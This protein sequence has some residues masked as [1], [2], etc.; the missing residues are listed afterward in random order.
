MS[1][2]MFDFCLGNSPYQVESKG[3]NDT[4]AMPVYHY[5]MDASSKIADTTVLIH[6]ARFL[7]GIG[8][9]PKKF[10]EE[11]LNDD[12]FKVLYY[13]PDASKVFPNTDIK[14]GIVITTENRN[15][16]YKKI[17]VFIPYKS[18][19]TVFSKVWEEN[20]ESFQ[21]L[22]SH[23]LI[24]HYSNAFFD[25]FPTID[26]TKGP[27]HS[28]QSDAFDKNDFV[29]LKAKNENEAFYEFLGKTKKESGRVWRYI[30]KEYIQNN[31][32]LNNWK[33]LIS[34]SVGSGKF[35]ETL[36]NPIVAKP[37]TGGTDTFICIGP[38]NCKD[39]AESALKYIST[40]FAR[41][42]LGILRRT[43]GNTY[44]VWKY[45][46]LQDFTDHSDIDWSKSIPEIDQQLYRKYGL[47][48]EEIDFIETH[49][50]EMK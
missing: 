41:A 47:S 7:F 29:F 19:E 22:I 3:D 25:D 43:Q 33:I 42:M 11:K 21:K 40:K 35:G 27:L 37:G 24:F 34:R 28:V 20:V 32:Y 31:I 2:K 13:E 16:V 46:P 30:K 39:E 36:S 10:T 14:G 5:F 6:P 12:H 1:K 48:D 9:T 26:K 38:F 23:R 45:V 8:R 15:V 44:P 50:K 4:L 17:K 18:M 49:V